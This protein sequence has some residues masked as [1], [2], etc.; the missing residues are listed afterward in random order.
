MGVRVAMRTHTGETRNSDQTFP[1]LVA[2]FASEGICGKSRIELNRPSWAESFRRVKY[3]ELKLPPSAVLCRWYGRIFW[4]K[5]GILVRRRS[6]GKSMQV[7]Q[8]R[9]NREICACGA[10]MYACGA[11]IYA[12]ACG[13]K[14]YAPGTNSGGLA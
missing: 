3:L 12:Y 10:K 8:I 9:E 6:L 5:A 2:R 14:I 4:P 7:Y 1:I 11:K 13:A